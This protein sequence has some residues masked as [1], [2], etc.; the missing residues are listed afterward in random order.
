MNAITMLTD[1]RRAVKELPADCG[2]RMAARRATG[3]RE[4]AGIR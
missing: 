2:S 3:V 1:D 4:T